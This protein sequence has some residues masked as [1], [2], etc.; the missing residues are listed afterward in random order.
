MG[1]LVEICVE[2]VRSAIAAEEGGADRVELC[3]DMGVGGLTPAPGDVAEACR[4]LRIPV[5]VLIRPRA[6]DFVYSD[7][8]FAAMIRSVDN[9]KASG[10]SGVVLGLNL[11]SGEIDRLRTADLVARARPL[12]VT[13]HKAFDELHDPLGGLDELLEIGIERV[14]TSGLAAT[15]REGLTL[16]SELTQRASGRIA[17]MAGGRVTEPD[18]PVLLAA[19]LREV[20]VGS[21]V[22]TAGATDPERVRSL[23]EAVRR[24]DVS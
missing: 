13:F 12:S 16:L 10:A 23:V 1:V 22:M 11:A 14:L 6:G 19:G 7:D 21:S 24:L 18:I 9:V 15:A 3:V 2:G 5:Q 17:V 20:H 8:E 4:L